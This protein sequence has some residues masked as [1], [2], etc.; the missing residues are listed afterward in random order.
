MDYNIERHPA[1]YPWR[2][3][4]P[5]A[6]RLSRGEGFAA[7]SAETSGRWWIIVDEGSIADFLDEE[8][9]AACV[10][11]EEFDDA[12]R[13]RQRCAEVQGRPAAVRAQSTLLRY[14]DAMPEL[15]VA[16]CAERGLRTISERD[17]L[18][19]WTAELLARLAPRSH[20][21]KTAARLEYQEHLPR[22]GAVDIALVN[23]EAKPIFLE[24]KCGAKADS[25]GPCVWD[26]LKLAVTIAAGDCSAGYLIA[27]SHERWFA[28]KKLG[29][30]LLGATTWTA[31]ELA[32]TYASWWRHWEKA[33]DPP[34]LRVPYSGSTE[35]LGVANF[36]LDGVECSLRVARV[37]VDPGRWYDWIPF[38]T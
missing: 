16:R 4:F 29:T 30:E 5:G 37:H 13:W 24:L 7:Y 19:P 18:Q 1:G 32:E 6:E 17:H 2:R 15:I 28:E 14:L 3:R 8:D 34:I 31:P 21:V 20:E 10:L 27:A 9:L 23:A 38:L 25:L 36:E 22:V 33:G 12:S 11:I 35:P 26:L